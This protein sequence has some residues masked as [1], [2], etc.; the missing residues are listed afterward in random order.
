MGRPVSF[1]LLGASFAKDLKVRPRGPQSRANPSSFFEENSLE[2]LNM[3]SQSQIDTIMSQRAKARESAKVDSLETREL[4]DDDLQGKKP[5]VPGKAKE[6][7]FKV[8]PSCRPSAEIRSYLSLD[9]IASGDVG[10]VEA[11]GYGFQRTG[12]PVI[13]PDRL[14]NIG[15]RPVPL[16]EDH[17]SLIPPPSPL[18]SSGS[19]IFWN[20]PVPWDN[21]TSDH[22]QTDD[23]A[24]VEISEEQSSRL[25]PGELPWFLDAQATFRF[26]DACSVPL[27]P[28]TSEEQASLLESGSQMMEEE[29]K[30]GR[31]HKEPL[32]VDHGVAISEESVGLGVPDIITQ[33]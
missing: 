30:E 13:H 5:W 22:K 7:Q 6:C 9:G 2:Q 28:P 10:P 29:M 33:M 19:S 20:P 16:P 18:S 32:Q 15:W 25:P 3:Y 1:D 8:C 26:F 14:A 12:R 23:T 4:F 21:S 11:I 24:S 17:P 31:F 27:P